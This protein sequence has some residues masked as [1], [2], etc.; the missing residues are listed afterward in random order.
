MKNIP[1]DRE[2]ER[3]CLGACLF[4]PQEV[5]GVIAENG[6][7]NL[8]YSPQNVCIWKAIYSLHVEGNEIDQ[9]TVTNELEKM[10][11]LD[12]IGGESA[13]ASFGGMIYLGNIKAWVKI[14]K[15]KA[16]LR[17]GIM[18]CISMEGMF[19]EGKITGE[20]VMQVLEE[21]VAMMKEKWPKKIS[22]LT[23]K[24]REW[25]S[26]SDGEFSV[27]QCYENLNLVSARYK[28]AARQAIF[29]LC[30][31]GVII[32]V[33][34]RDGV[35]RKVD[36]DCQPLDWTTAEN[37]E[38]EIRFP[39]GLHE[40]VRLLPGNIMLIAGESN[41]GKTA[42]SMRTAAINMKGEKEIHYFS[43]EMGVEE[44]KE[45]VEGFREEGWTVDAWTKYIRFYERSYGYADVLR[46][47]AINIFDYMETPSD[48][49]YLVGDYLRDIHSKLRSGIAIVNLQRAKGADFG[50]GG[51]FTLDKPRLYINIE[52]NRVKIVKAKL[53]RNHEF[54]PNGQ[55]RDFALVNGCKF[56]SKS[57][58]YKAEEKK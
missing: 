51:Q 56:V 46:P 36:N 39:L 30:K 9:L 41:A 25:V 17:T 1:Q 18:A 19:R 45:R 42:F 21:Q 40:L 28:N 57:E 38:F 33:G 23:D 47:D 16:I 55:A 10:G 3:S 4:E 34:S 29:S 22:G 13:V 48:K 11:K 49:P 58:W 50:R 24:I 53:W 52:P 37:T 20:E 15:D 5:V 6:G 43:S 12:Q 27:R 26:V 2:I 54:N 32:R 14:L 31:E 8:F 44:F 35:Y 7:E